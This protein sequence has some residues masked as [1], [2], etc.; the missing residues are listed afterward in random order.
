MPDSIKFCLR[1]PWLA[2]RKR[3]QTRRYIGQG[4]IQKAHA[5]RRAGR[6]RS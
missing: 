2:P 4:L 5:C 6:G 1:L 3:H